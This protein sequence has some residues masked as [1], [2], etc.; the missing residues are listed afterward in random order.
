[1]GWYL[2]KSVKMGP[3]R[4][5]FS[6]RGVGVSTGVKGFRVGTGPRGPYVAGGRGGLY[7]RQKLGPAAPKRRAHPPVSP[8]ISSATRTPSPI[9]SP[10]VQ[11]A[12]PQQPFI[13]GPG[14]VIPGYPQRILTPPPPRTYRTYSGI[15][16]GAL[17]GS[18]VLGWLLMAAI[19][20][21]GVP[22]W[23]ASMI[24]VAIMDWHGFISLRGRIPWW[25]LSDMQ[26]FWI[27]CA[28]LFVYDI[29]VPIY[30]V[31]AIIDYRK[32]RALAPMQT[33]LRTAQLESQLGIMPQTDGTCRHCGKPLQVGAEFCAYCRTPVVARPRICPAC[34]APVL[35]DANWCPAC[36]AALPPT[37]DPATT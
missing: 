37:T 19:P 11:P 4:I 12:M 22:V 3:V 23:I 9:P 14:P 26:R 33:R 17:V 15:A 35:P 5:N 8:P 30:L 34:A 28:Y 20:D 21:L 25:R 31:C 1:M 10:G 13:P 36:G 2:R 29:M 18:H 24:A 27:V 6:K 16:L 32:Q 7:F